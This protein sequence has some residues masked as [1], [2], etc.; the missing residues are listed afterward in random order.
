MRKVLWKCGKSDSCPIDNASAFSATCGSVGFSGQS[1]LR[2]CKNVE[3]SVVGHILRMWL[4][5]YIKY[6]QMDFN[7]T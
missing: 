3:K 4:C 1:Y 5:T 6:R 2:S 7:N